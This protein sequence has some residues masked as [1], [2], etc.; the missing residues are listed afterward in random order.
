[1]TFT[2]KQ[3]KP[4]KIQAVADLREVLASNTL[5]LTDYQGLDVK[6]LS[7]LRRKLRE[8]GCGYVVVKNTLFDLAANDLP[9]KS[10]TEGLAGPT[11][12]VH[13]NEDPVAAAKT[14][15]E[16]AKGPKTVKSRPD[17]WMGRFTTP[18]RWRLFRRFHR[19]RNFMRWWSEDSRARLRGWSALCISSWGS[20]CLHC[21]Q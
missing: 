8:A 18:N 6:S 3:P 5:I 2:K 9:A 16:F 15:Q 11:A 10:L 4:E 20:S 17:W 1:M 21:R 12:I 14:L 7:N 13:T 19:S